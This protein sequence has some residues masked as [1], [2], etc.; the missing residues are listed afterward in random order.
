MKNKILVIEDDRAISELL[1][2][3]LEAA[4]YETV[5]A[6]DGE[7]A[8][9]LL[10]WQEDADLAVV[11]IMLPGKDGF[12][13]MEDFKKKELPVLYLTAKDDVASK[14]KGLKLGAEDYM[15]K[16]FE[17]LELLVR[18]E[19]VLERTG[20]AKKVLT[21][22]NI[23]VDIQSHQVYK[24]G[25]PVSL[26]PMEYDLFVLLLQNKNI[27]LGREELLKRVWGENYLGESRT[28]DVHIGQLRKKLDFMMRS[29]QS[30]NLDTVWRNRDEAV[31]T[32]GTSYAGNAIVCPDPSG[33]AKSL[34]HRKTKPQ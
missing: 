1:C 9:R 17:M 33:N 8:Q 25:L 18:I 2:M 15:V 6:Y 11:D 27:A 24:D 28:V 32:N 13:L 12:A 34:Y 16:P 3:N 4:G 26:K 5:A 23:L 29:G 30:R 20:R 19:K 7:E 10:L 14:V 21:V 22:R 31:E